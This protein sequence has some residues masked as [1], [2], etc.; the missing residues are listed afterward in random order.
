MKGISDIDK[1]GLAKTQALEKKAEETTGDIFKQALEHAMG[2]PGKSGDVSASLSSAT[3]LGEI[4][5]VGFPI[6]QDESGGLE[7]ETDRL[8]SLFDDYTKALGDPGQTLK[9]IESL[10]EDIKNGAEQISEMI[11]SGMPQ[12]DSLTSIARESALLANVEYIKF[13]RG[14]YV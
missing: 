3:S 8:L 7:Q 14:D 1:L 12:T 10:L 13:M 9:D 11:G 4:Q 2:S 5:A 6:I